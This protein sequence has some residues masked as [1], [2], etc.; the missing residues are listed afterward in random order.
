MNEEDTYT[1]S[2]TS[3]FRIPAGGYVVFIFNTENYKAAIVPNC[4]SF[5]CTNFNG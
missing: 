4:L 3:N 5:V 1:F 2:F